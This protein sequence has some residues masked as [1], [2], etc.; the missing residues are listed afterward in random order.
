[1]PVSG[2]TKTNIQ[3][4]KSDEEKEKQQL[5]EKNE[6]NRGIGDAL[7]ESKYNR[8]KLLEIQ[9]D[10]GTRAWSALYQQRPSA[11]EGWLIKKAWFP[12]GSAYCTLR[13]FRNR[14]EFSSAIF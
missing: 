13:T 1:M 11:E 6:E 4:V 14:S 5:A 10:V 9:K 7:W 12:K 2:L 3:A 8:V